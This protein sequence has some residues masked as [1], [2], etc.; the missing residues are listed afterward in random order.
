M[1]LRARI[2]GALSQALS[3][4]GGGGMLLIVVW[5]LIGAI[6]GGMLGGA[7][8]DAAANHPGDISAIF[9]G[10]VIGA[11]LGAAAAGFAARALTRKYPVGSP[12]RPRL[13][14]ATWVTPLAVVLGSVAF[15]MVR[16]AD[17]LKPGGGAA[18][19]V[20]EVRLPPGSPAPAETDVAAEF[21]T[22][23]ET[24]KQSFPGHDLDVVSV[25]DRAVI[26][27]SFESYRTA[28]QRTLR[29]R[30]GNGPTHVFAL[31]LLP[32]RPPLGYAKDF[33]EWH[34][35]QDVEEAGKPPRPPLP[36]E[37][38]EIRYMMNI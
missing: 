18:W 9:G 16:S 17:T 15:E 5:V 21:R 3:V 31:K 6:T 8:G 7:L 34:G 25:G 14:A 10:L 1:R 38:L 13:V 24:R 36:S 12:G 29:I 11:P 23:K 30:I 2:A 32:P 37:S 26:R 19:L 4:E 22:E 35:A 33:S 20:Y 27:G 28:Q